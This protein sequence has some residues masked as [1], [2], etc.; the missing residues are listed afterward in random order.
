MR[1]LS[2]GYADTPLRLHSHYHEGHQ[3][4]FVVGGET[5]VTVGTQHYHMEPGSLL[6]LSRLEEHSIHGA[7]PEYRRYTLRVAP[8][9]STPSNQENALLFS[10]L[11][12]RGAGFRHVIALGDRAPIF[13]DLFAEMAREYASEAPMREEM[14]ALLFRRFLIL[15]LRHAPHLFLTEANRSTRLIQAIQQ[16]IEQDCRENTPLTKLAEE[17]HVSTSHLAHLF[18]RITGY[19]LMEYRQACRL[20]TAKGLLSSTQKSIK[21]IVEICG[22]GDES[23]FSRK[24]REKTGMTP[25]EF[26]RQNRSH[27]ENVKKQS[28]N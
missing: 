17:Y 24:F 22:F 6:L 19:A 9:A 8:E 12:N 13:E 2:V 5:D 4:L 7:T 21:E 11:V 15:L 20:T 18:K 25:S 14:L 16:R 26:R 3:L 1:V 27:T 10:V 28:K 23:N